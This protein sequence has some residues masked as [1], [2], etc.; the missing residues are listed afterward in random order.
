M[1][2]MFLILTM[3]LATTVLFASATV[4]N[5]KVLEAF[6]KEFVNVQEVRWTEGPDYS[7]AQF[8]YNGQSVRA[9]YTNSGQSLGLFRYISSLNLPVNLQ[10]SLKKSYGNFWITD[11][12]E[13]S[14]GGV[15][16]YF[17]TIEDADESVMLK[18]SSDVD[19]VQF[20]SVEK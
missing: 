20:K 17:I 14:K 19:W 13:L 11:L 10:L 1:K 12:Y 15:T 6:T 2:K 18:A 3:S 8:L 7:I 5:P 4:V 9:Y 16:N